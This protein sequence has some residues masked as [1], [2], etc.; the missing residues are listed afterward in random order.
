MPTVEEI[1]F[2]K[3]QGSNRGIYIK[4]SKNSPLKTHEI[5]LEIAKM[6]VK[7]VGDKPASYWE[8]K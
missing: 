1:C 3:I 8:N 4:L 6:A 2:D 7:A 5:I